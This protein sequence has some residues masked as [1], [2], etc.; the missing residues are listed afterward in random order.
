MIIDGGF[1]EIDLTRLGFDRILVDQPMY[2][3][4]IV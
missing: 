1:L 3:N 4:N 2:E